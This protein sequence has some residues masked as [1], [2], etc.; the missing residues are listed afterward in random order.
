MV[1]TDVA[2]SLTLGAFAV[3]LVV[4][5]V[6]ID[7]H[8]VFHLVTDLELA[9]PGQPPPAF[10]VSQVSDQMLH[11]G[12]PV[13]NGRL[14]GHSGVESLAFLGLESA[15]D[16]LLPLGAVIYVDNILDRRGLYCSTLEI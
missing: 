16:L 1:E 2:D 11:V 8:Q 3:V 7:F 13:L 10:P 12:L 9:H 4:L 6:S 14:E 15:L 5:P